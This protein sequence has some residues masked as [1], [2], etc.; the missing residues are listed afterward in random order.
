[1]RDRDALADP[2]GDLRRRAAR[3]DLT[4]ARNLREA[5]VDA[6][7]Q[8][9]TDAEDR[10]T[11]QFAK[12]LEGFGLEQNERANTRLDKYGRLAQI[13]ESGWKIDYQEYRQ[14]GQWELPRKLKLSQ[15]RSVNGEQL[16]SV[17][18][19]VNTWKVEG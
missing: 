19:V 18:L 4:A 12:Q 10:F 14:F 11:P 17:R 15:I 16:V 13:T 9:R 6:M 2:G 8:I 5:R 7:E 3:G 1:M